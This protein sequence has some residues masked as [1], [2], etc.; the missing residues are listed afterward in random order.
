MH[1]VR[2]GLV[3]IGGIRRLCSEMVGTPH[4]WPDAWPHR[5]F[6]MSVDWASVKAMARAMLFTCMTSAANRLG[7]TMAAAGTLK[8]NRDQEAKALSLMAA[9]TLPSHVSY[10]DVYFVDAM[11]KKGA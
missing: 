5:M 9:V 4:T 1:E 7:C 11:S 10:R 3:F 2:R 8:S 6:V